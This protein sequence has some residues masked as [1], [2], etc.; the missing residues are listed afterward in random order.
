MVTRRGV[1]KKT[2]L[3]DFEYQRKSGKIALALD[4]GDELLFVIKT[5]G[6]SNILLATRQG[7]ALKYSEQTVRSMGR[8]ARGVRGI[9]LRGDDEVVGAVLVEPEKKLVTITENGYG[10]Q[11]SFE[12]FREMKN[13]GGHGVTCHN[14]TEKTGLLAGIVTVSDEDDLMLI[15]DG[16]IIIRVPSTDIPTYSRTAGGVIVMR[17]SSDQKIVNFTA[18]P[19]EEEKEDQ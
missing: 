19:R 12:D 15:T 8:T 11:T 9:S 14:I 3:S 4:E 17:A 5:D 18:V 10:K 6:N 7:A 16:G 2:V 13:R 1:I